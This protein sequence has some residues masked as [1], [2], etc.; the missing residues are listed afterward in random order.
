MILTDEQ[1]IAY[2]KANQQVDKRITEARKQSKELFALLEGD[3]FK[4]E[5][6]RNIEH[7]ESKEKAL[8]RKK[9]SRSVVDF[10]ERLSQP[11]SNVFS[12]T[13][14]SKKYDLQD[15]QLETLLN[16]I[17]DIR[18]GKSIERYLDETWMDLYHTDPNGLIFLEYRTKPELK[19]WCTYK[20]TFECKPHGEHIDI[21][22]L[23]NQVKEKK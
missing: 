13:G 11:I 23:R 20:F 8:A 7:I 5:L 16:K 14:G 19:V 21:E 2:I 3:M 17:G 1:A 10:F 6:I 12:A 4:E 18:G 15:K 9:Y 22:D